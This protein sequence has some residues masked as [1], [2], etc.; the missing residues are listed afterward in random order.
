MLLAGL[1][2]LLSYITQDCLLRG[3]PHPSNLGLSVLII[4]Q[5]N[6]PQANLMAAVPQQRFPLS[7]LRLGLCPVDK[8]PTSTLP[9]PSMARKLKHGVLA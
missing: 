5:E 6:A 7:Q 9:I 1:F 4:N 8:K 3:G 2:N